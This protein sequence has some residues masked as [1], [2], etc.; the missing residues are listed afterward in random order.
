M[1]NGRTEDEEGTEH[2][3]SATA[4]RLARLR[5]GAAAA[6]GAITAAEAELRAAAERRVTAEAI[7]R[8]AAARHQAAARALTAHQRHRPGT[9]TQLITWFRAGQRWHGK[10]ARLA[11]AAAASERPLADARL[12]LAQA[13]A[14]FSA[15]VD[16]RARAV[17]ELRR[18]TAECEAAR[19]EAA[20]G[21]VSVERW[22]EEAQAEPV[23]VDAAQ[24]E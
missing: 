15:L 23:D 21:E 11:D 2:T 24:A 7:L 22:G 5:E 18:L 17:T 4:A 14:Q 6:Y 19:G 12:M 9:V 1:P 20:R 8:R 3:A 13:K 10:Q 16:A